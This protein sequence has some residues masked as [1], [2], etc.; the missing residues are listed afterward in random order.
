MSY[1]LYLSCS[2]L[3]VLAGCFNPDDDDAA[4]GSSDTDADTSDTS[5]T[6]DTETSVGT[7]DPTTGVT[8]DDTDDGSDT[9]DPTGEDTDAEPVCG[10]GIVNG[11]EVCDDGINDG[12]YGSCLEDC[13]GYA[14]HCGDG[15]VNGD[16]VCDDGVN[17]GGYDGCAQD[18]QSLGPFC[19]DGVVQDDHEMCDEG[20]DN[21]NGSGCNVDCIV[22]GTQLYSWT[23]P[24]GQ[25]C[26]GD[27]TA[28]VIRADGNVH[29]AIVEWCGSSQHLVELTPELEEVDQSAVLF[30]SFPSRA[31]MRGDDWLLSAWNCD[32]SISEND[33]L[34][35]I[36]DNDR[37]TGSQALQAW[38][39]Q[40][41]MTM[42][43]GVVAR[44]GAGSPAQDDSPLW[45]VTAPANTA[46]VTYS[47]SHAAI[48]ELGA[49]VAAGWYR[50][51]QSSP[52]TYYG[53]LRRWTAG[54]N[55]QT[56]PIFSQMQYFYEIVA[57]PDG[58]FVI[59]GAGNDRHLMKV[60]ASL[61]HVWSKAGNE[62]AESVICPWGPQR[63]AVDSVGD[64][65][66]DCET[67]NWPQ[68]T[69]LKLDS[70]GNE[71]WGIVLEAE[72]WAGHMIIDENDWIIRTTID[73]D[74]YYGDNVTFRVDK[75]AP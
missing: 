73:G 31:T 75:I 15:I 36:C 71:R 26:G 42:K 54:G 35:E 67:N 10:D 57:S 25:Y 14:E 41:Y 5:G 3:L 51:G 30:P 29:F 33:T 61:N 63:I 40:F 4:V 28:P 69:M 22:S 46:N 58:G 72:A 65:I 2:A 70:A 74:A 53:Y 34:T 50:V 60:D 44:W 8:T 68:R 9:D 47:L 19:G 56:S 38:D 17:D 43:N 18:C 16:E 55:H 13:S 62:F 1:R 23:H 64:I 59:R 49:V 21:E 7:N 27:I 20:E 52:Y 6:A 48:G 39:D 66:A 24:I 45:Q 11:D 32:Y 12:S 37:I